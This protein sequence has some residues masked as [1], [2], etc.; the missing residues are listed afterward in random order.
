[1]PSKITGQ[2]GTE[3]VPDRDDIGTEQ[4]ATARAQMKAATS[5]RTGT[6]L[7]LSFLLFFFSF[8]F[9]NSLGETPKRWCN[10]TGKAARGSFFY[11]FF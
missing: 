3:T 8:L 2:R 10:C 6:S 4:R 11:Y 9:F 1:M 5:E 7:S